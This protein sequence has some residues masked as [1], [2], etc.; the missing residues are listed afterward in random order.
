MT[1]I[2]LTDNGPVDPPASAVTA[3]TV[4][5]D[6]E[7][8]L[9]DFEASRDE[10]KQADPTVK[11]SATTKAGTSAAASESAQATPAKK[12]RRRRQKTTEGDAPARPKDAGDVAAMIASPV[13]GTKELG[14]KLEKARRNM[15][16]SPD[17]EKLRAIPQPTAETPDP[18]IAEKGEAAGLAP[19]PP[20]GA[21][22]SI[23]KAGTTAR[24]GRRKTQET[25]E[26]RATEPQDKV[27]R[28]ET[29]A[30]S[31]QSAR[32][33]RSDAK[34]EHVK[35]ETAAPTDPV[36][37]GPGKAR[38][39]DGKK[40]KVQATKPAGLMAGLVR[41]SDSGVTDFE[42]EAE[43]SETD[44][45]GDREDNLGDDSAATAA[46][47]GDGL[48]ARF[49]DDGVPTGLVEDIVP[50]RLT[51]DELES[52]PCRI[53]GASADLPREEEEENPAVAALLQGDWLRESPQAGPRFF[54]ESEFAADPP[55]APDD[56]HPRS[57]AEIEA[58][59][60]AI[61]P[62]FGEEEAHFY[63]ERRPS[64]PPQ[65]DWKDSRGN[66]LA[67]ADY[68]LRMDAWEKAVIAGDIR[69]GSDV[70]EQLRIEERRMALP[71]GTDSTVA[72]FPAPRPLR[73]WHREGEPEETQVCD[74][75]AEADRL[76]TERRETD[77]TDEKVDEDPNDWQDLEAM[78]DR[79]ARPG[80]RLRY[81]LSRREALRPALFTRW[82]ASDTSLKMAF[83][84]LLMTG[85]GALSGW[86]AARLTVPALVEA[87]TPVAIAA[88]VR[89]D[90]VRELMVM[91]N[92][93]RRE[94][95]K[96]D[97][98]P[99]K[100]ST[101][102]L[103]ASLIDADGRPV[104]GLLSDLHFRAAIQQTADLLGAPVMSAKT[105]LAIP[106]AGEEKHPLATQT[107]DI[108]ENVKALLGLSRL[109]NAAARELLNDW[110]KEES[111]RDQ[112][113]ERNN[114]ERHS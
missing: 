106:K 95:L 93:L 71:T 10:K 4:N 44:L 22:P 87:S 72:G 96:S 14:L 49:R 103:P 50:R 16:E 52:L 41:A 75:R 83:T 109:E 3:G 97:R 73:R 85:V 39:T 100:L 34:T 113:N 91:A 82:K 35:N 5:A 90:D 8:A 9:A 101:R 105:V 24:R 60:R 47:G 74:P 28:A 32:S 110:I 53:P 111:A 66:R 102:Y 108:T 36:E 48:D 26:T 57:K 70:P 17:A 78:N 99:L 1:T 6:Y 98:D 61:S 84:A 2:P 59:H 30:E 65:P 31:V 104:E 38:K 54:R 33:A 19:I 42:T 114:K 92:L 46:P 63:A 15:A 77:E 56:G 69:K 62:H 68:A 64:Q 51:S 86:L 20:K 43:E 25:V 45:E 40:A 21:A 67:E 88:I 81:A 23:E 80:D 12:T 58:V 94:G 107:L 27:D 18:W 89:D 37:T 79:E 13:D 11:A 76:M 55:E 7:D 112:K 29:V